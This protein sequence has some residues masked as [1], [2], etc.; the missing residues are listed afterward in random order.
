VP[1]I[2]QHGAV[3]AV[4]QHLGARQGAVLGDVAHHEDGHM[5]LLGIACQQ[6]R[7]LP[8]LGDGTRRGLHIRHVH[9]LDGVDDH[10]LRLLLLGDET[11]LLDAGLGQHAQL[12]RG[13][14]Q[15]TGPHRHLLQ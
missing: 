9:H 4:L 15:P 1:A 6:R 2:Q 14:T 8:H 5:I 10:D 11:D 3:D 7:R 12:V 13:Q